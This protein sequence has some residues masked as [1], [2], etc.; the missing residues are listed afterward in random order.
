[1]DFYSKALVP[2]LF[3]INIFLIVRDKSNIVI[4]FSYF[5]GMEGMF[6]HS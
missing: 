6:V 1:M 2:T 3:F 5:K 4:K